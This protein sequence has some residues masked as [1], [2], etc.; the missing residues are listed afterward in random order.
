LSTILNDLVYPSNLQDIHK[1]ILFCNQNIFLFDT[2]IEENFKKFYEYKGI[3]YLS[4]KQMIN[5]LDICCIN[6]P[7]NTDCVTMSGGEK[8][9]VF[10]AICLSFMPIV[11]MLDEP[12]SAL[13]DQNANTLINNIKT[14][15]TH[16]SI[17]LIIVC[18]NKSIA[19][20]FADNIV[21]L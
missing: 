3:P 2:T 10:I 14:F 13:D 4:E 19:E 7:L 17:T 18:H 1:K 15:C 5:Y 6:F 9:R 11:L 8:H 21:N 20:K 12:T 16:H